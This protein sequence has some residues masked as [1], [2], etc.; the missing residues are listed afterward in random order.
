MLREAVLVLLIGVNHCRL[1]PEDSGQRSPSAASGHSGQ[2]QRATRSAEIDY[3]VLPVTGFRCSQ[4]QYP[5]IYADVE[6]GCQLFHFCEASGKNSTFFCPSLT[7]FNQQFFVCDWAY[8]VECSAATQFYALNQNIYITPDK[9]YAAQPLIGTVDQTAATSL[10]QP[11]ILSVS[12]GLAKGQDSVAHAA[13]NLDNK[14][15]FI[16]LTFF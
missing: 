5:G 1:I 14:V 16:V 10:R 12:S 3:P 11:K 13:S 9:I 4:Q 15:M 2:G 6:A 8:N 7:L